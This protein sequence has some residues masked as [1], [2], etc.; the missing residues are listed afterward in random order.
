MAGSS[1]PP[2]DREAVAPAAKSDAGVVDVDVDALLA[3][4]VKVCP[5]LC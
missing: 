4:K 1:P 3:E 2:K 5:I